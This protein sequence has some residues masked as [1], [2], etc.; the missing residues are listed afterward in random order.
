MQDYVY[1]WLSHVRLD[2]PIENSYYVEVDHM[3]LSIYLKDRS[4]WNIHSII[5]LAETIQYVNVYHLFWGFLYIV[6]QQTVFFFVSYILTCFSVQNSFHIIIKWHSS[7]ASCIIWDRKN[8]SF[9]QIRHVYILHVY[10]WMYVMNDLG[11]PHPT[12]STI[13]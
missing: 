8:K 13:E 11:F 5:V 7:N 9:D 1:R 4:I 6:K 10:K 3:K 12:T 2:R